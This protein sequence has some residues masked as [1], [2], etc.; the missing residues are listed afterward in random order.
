MCSDDN[1]IKV[2]RLVAISMSLS[3]WR[4]ESVT[5][6]VHSFRVTATVTPRLELGDFKSLPSSNLQAEGLS[7]YERSD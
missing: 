4:D 1:L 5:S 6:S 3:P 2:V 7:E